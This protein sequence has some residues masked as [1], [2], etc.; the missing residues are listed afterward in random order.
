MRGGGGVGWTCRA[1][2]AAPPAA[3]S[4]F[5]LFAV[6]H[7]SDSSCHEDSL[8]PHS[9]LGAGPLPLR[10]SNVSDNA[11]L[12]A[13]AQV[14]LNRHADVLREL[15]TAVRRRGPRA[16]S[17]RRQCARRVARPAGHRP[18]FHHRRPARADAEDPAAVGR[19]AVGY[20]HRVRHRRRRQ[21]RRTGWRSPRSAPT[22]TTRCRAIPQVR[23]G[24]RL[25]DDLVRRDFT[26][27][28]MAVRITAAGPGEFHRS[29]RRFGG[30]ARRR[31][32][33]A[34]GAGGV[35]RRRSAADAARGAVRLAARLHR[36][37][38]GAR[39]R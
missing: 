17:G 39:Q 12:L 14:A 2:A 1:A 10:S 36:R 31:A 16:V 30:A 33:H 38:A 21:G 5:G 25:D 23:F 19:R 4:W 32:G 8:P 9:P 18:R 20:R 15:G 13:A 22:P 35:V 6:R 34:G 26:V 37:A 24:D 3:P 29:P 7:P 27:N 11:E 28:A